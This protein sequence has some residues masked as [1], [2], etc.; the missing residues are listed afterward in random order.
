[1]AGFVPFSKDSW[2]REGD[3]IGRAAMNTERAY[4][5]AWDELSKPGL[6][7]YLGKSI[8]WYYAVGVQ[9]EIVY[10]TNGNKVPRSE[11][12]KP[13]MDLP[14]EFPADVDFE[15]YEQECEKILKA[16]GYQ[17]D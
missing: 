15:W 7:E 12:A 8:R 16:I 17:V 3:T 2:V 1:M 4:K 13:M 9:G 14:D 10:A 5:A 6:T 11:G